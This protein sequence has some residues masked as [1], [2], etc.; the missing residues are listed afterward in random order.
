MAAPKKG[1]RTVTVN[2]VRFRW[3]IRRKPTYS[4]ALSEGRFCMTVERFDPPSRYILWLAAD[5]PRPGNWFRRA[6][7]AVT[8]QMIAALSR[9]RLPEGGSPSSLVRLFSIHY[10]LMRTRDAMARSPRKPMSAVIFTEL[11]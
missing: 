9:K 6:S 8:P 10:V 5:F 2:G 4:Q 1:S 3:R 7:K 11:P